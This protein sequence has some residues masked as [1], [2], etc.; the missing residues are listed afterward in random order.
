MRQNISGK[1]GSYAARHKRRSHWR[2]LLMALAC[3][4]VFCTTYALILPA[5]TLENPEALDAP[6]CGLE[7]HIHS[8]SCFEAR[9]E[10]QHKQFHC[11]DGGGNLVGISSDLVLHTHDEQC[12]D[13]DG[14]LVCPLPEITAHTHDAS[15]YHA[16]LVSQGHH[17]TE[18]CISEWVQGEL[19]CA[20]PTEAHVHGEGCYDGSGE[21]ICQISEQAHV[22]TDE[23]YE[24]LPVYSCN[25]EESEDVYGEQ[26]LTC[27]RRE[28]FPHTHSTDCY[29]GSGNLTCGH[30]QVVS[31]QH[32]AECYDLVTVPAQTVQTCTIPEHTHTEAC[33]PQNSEQ[34]EGDEEGAVPPAS[35]GPIKA[36]K[37]EGASHDFTNNINTVK[38]ERQSSAGGSWT[39]VT[40]GQSVSEGDN[41]RFTLNYTLPIGT[42]SSENN[43]M[44]Y[45]LP[46]QITLVR[47]DRGKVT[48]DAGEYIGDYVI[49]KDGMISITFLEDRAAGNQESPVTGRVS[50]EAKV[51]DITH[52]DNEID[53]TFKEGVT[54]NVP[55]GQPEEAHTDLTVGK[56]ASNIDQEAGTVDYTITVYSQK[57]TDSEVTLTDS[58]TLGKLFSGDASGI[59]VMDKNGDPVEIAPLYSENENGSNFSMTLPRMTAGDFYTI[60]YTV[61]TNLDTISNDTF[62]TNT[63]N[64]RSTNEDG[65]E[66]TGNVTIT[67]PFKRTDIGKYGYYNQGDDTITWTVTI[68]QAKHDIGGWTLSDVFNRKD[69]T[70]NVTIK[71]S[72]GS[73][74]G[75]ARLPYTFAGGS[76]DTYTVTYTTPADKLIGTS[77]AVNVANLTPPEGHGD[78]IT[79]GENSV[80][81]GNSFEPVKKTA[82]SIIMDESSPEDKRTAT[83]TWTV[84]VDATEGEISAPWTLRDEPQ[85]GHGP[86]DKRQE[87][88]IPG[89]QM[90]VVKETLTSWKLNMTKLEAVTKEGATVDLTATDADPNTTYT[91]FTATFDDSLPKGEKKQFTYSTTGT[92]E[93][94]SSQIRFSNDVFLNEFKRWG[95]IAYKPQAPVVEKT[96]INGSGDN[97]SHD[98]YDDGLREGEEQGILKWLIKVT[99]PKGYQGGPITL[100]EYL[101]EGAELSYLEFLADGI[102]GARDITADKTYDFEGFKIEKRQEGQVITVI[103]PGELAEHSSLKEFRFVV[104]VRAENAPWVNDENGIPTAVFPNKVVITSE[105]EGELGEDIQ[106]QTITKDDFKDVI[107]K[108]HGDPE[109]NVIPYSLAINPKGLD[110]VEGVDYLILYD[111]LKTYHFGEFSLDA[112]LVPNSVMVYRMNPDG[113]KGARLPADQVPYTY[114]VVVEGS[115][116]STLC[117]NLTIRLPDGMPL[118]VEYSYKLIGD[119]GQWWNVANQATLQGVKTGDKTSST[120]VNTQIQHG[121]ATAN[122]QGVSLRKVDKDNYAITL[123]GAEFTLYQWKGKEYVPATA[124]VNGVENTDISYYKTDSNGAATLHDLSFNTAYKLVEINAPTNYLGQTEPYYFYIL[125]SDTKTHPPMKP[126]GFTGAELIAGEVIYFANERSDTDITVA[127][128]WLSYSG[129]DVTATQGGQISFELYQKASATPPSGSTGGSG[130]SATVTW[131]GT[132]WGTTLFTV[133]QKNVQYGSTVTFKLTANSGDSLEYMK[134]LPKINGNPMAWDGSRTFTYTCKLEQGMATAFET[135]SEDWPLSSC[136]LVGEISV[137]P[138]EV[139]EPSPDPADRLM[140]TF[141]ISPANGWTWSSKDVV[142]LPRRGVDDNGNTLYYSYYVKEVGIASGYHVFYINNDGI[143][144]GIITIQNQAPEHPSYSLPNTGGPGA[145][146]YMAGGLAI[147]SVSLLLLYIEIKLRRKGNASF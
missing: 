129:E 71:G 124:T 68:N 65:T 45:R 25:Q 58:M 130:N 142:T 46:A 55:I 57:G 115:D 17:H 132:R 23:C 97:T 79:T 144:S 86:G 74:I 30:L 112:S 116:N 101:P 69:F 125:N 8:E 15:C 42:L 73:V 11:C 85:Q 121:S 80:W 22:H 16:S 78:K 109:N 20:L 64:A 99:P 93:D 91:T 134:N 119:E 104:R 2:R 61:K 14:T 143:I 54:V 76:S 1:A 120:T 59:T 52:T 81:F 27:Q 146:M 89:A 88:T 4:V 44:H 136:T 141:T 36:P 90:Q 102:I 133:Q 49:T 123:S 51:E 9:P 77:Q 31:H 24:R 98:F 29:D 82:N 35:N 41:L 94:G 43:T 40:E 19:I 26:E 72:D 37:A 63:V 70:G 62:V 6:V 117:H 66:L 21:L 140:G 139:V 111:V 95:D 118:I 84:E 127:K 32:T 60:T 103:I 87:H 122:L 50:F 110:M 7:E 13:P 83:I 128:K 47:E 108:G 138:P 106:T 75:E 3:V 137:I 135:I 100:T 10:A 107:K 33:F 147:A 96:D 131:T 18:E 39:T 114:E 34:P 48:N 105:K 126:D 28:V 53:V 145:V 67:T 113:T 56:T 5:I 12:Y 38:L 92:I